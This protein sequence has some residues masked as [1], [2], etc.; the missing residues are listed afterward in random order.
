MKNFVTI[1]GCSSGGKSTLLA[2]LK[3]RGHVT[4]DE[5]GRRIITEELKRGGRAL[6]W[7]DSVAFALCVMEVS[8]ADY[9]GADASKGWVFFDRGLIDAAV[10]IELLTGEPVIERVASTYR[11]NK[12]VFLVPPWPEIYSVDSERR[13]SIDDAI[14]E[15]NRLTDVYP[16][17][18]YDIQVLPKVSVADRANILLASLER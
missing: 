16:S 15:Y 2:E 3:Q 5:P 13:H 18:G 14:A 10:A 12:R 6:P 8:L 9:S 4:I 1:S 11:F 17:L 7:A